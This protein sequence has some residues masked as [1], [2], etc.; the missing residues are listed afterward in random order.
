MNYSYEK[1]YLILD[2]LKKQIKENP[3]ISRENTGLDIEIFKIFQEIG[4]VLI[5]KEKLFFLNIPEKLNIDLHFYYRNIH[6][7][8]KIFYGD[9][10]VRFLI[11]FILFKVYQYLTVEKLIDI[12]KNSIGE[13]IIIEFN[14]KN[15][16]IISAHNFL[17]NCSLIKKEFIKTDT[18]YTDKD[19]VTSLKNTWIFKNDLLKKNETEIDY[20]SKILLNKL[21]TYL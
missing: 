10:R 14:I 1:L 6:K 12:I 3:L 5:E 16:N 7:M 11:H 9:V 8:H 21:I 13:N 19:C 20:I 4:F 15:E 2:G 17:V 18:L